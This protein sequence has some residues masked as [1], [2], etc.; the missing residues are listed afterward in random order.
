VVDTR[1]ANSFGAIATTKMA[2]SDENATQSRVA[3]LKAM[4][5]VNRIRQ[6]GS[7]LEAAN[8]NHVLLKFK[9]AN[10]E[11]V[12]EDQ[13]WVLESISGR[14]KGTKPFISFDAAKQSAGGNTGCN[15]FEWL[16]GFRRH[17]PNL[18][19]RFDNACCIEDDRM[20]IERNSWMHC[21]MLKSVS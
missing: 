9:A 5:R 8:G 16:R 4:V 15:V 21:K 17:D 10:D 13:K 1:A 18:R 20:E 11:I 12:L 2:C 19:H 6:I 7:R 14:K 3:D